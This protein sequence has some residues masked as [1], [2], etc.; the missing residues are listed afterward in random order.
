MTM[1]SN[2]MGELK[3]LTGNS[4]EAQ[5][6]LIKNAT[7]QLADSIDTAL[8]TT[9]KAINETNQKLVET[10]LKATDDRVDKVVELVETKLAKSELA[11]ELEKAK[12]TIEKKDLEEKIRKLEEKLATQCQDMEEKF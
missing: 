4:C 5:G 8:K 11:L 1:V 10:I 9:S 6:S 12:H 3:S 7:K 2:F